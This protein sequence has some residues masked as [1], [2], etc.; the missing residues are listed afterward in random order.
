VNTAKRVGTGD[1]DP[2]LNGTVAELPSDSTPAIATQA[3]AGNARRA[4]PLACAIIADR[5]RRAARRLAETFITNG[6]AGS[7]ADTA[8]GD[9]AIIL[10]FAL[11]YGADA[12]A[13][14][15]EIMVAGGILEPEPDIMT[16]WDAPSWRRAA[17]EYHRDRPGRLAV[18]IEPKRLARLRRLMADDVSLER[19]WHELRDKRSNFQKGDFR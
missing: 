4:T 10:S 17:V 6:K 3:I 16:A 18:E 19:A 5:E 7:S 12:E 11:Q 13:S 8:V 15:L 14:A 1:A 9:A 2:L